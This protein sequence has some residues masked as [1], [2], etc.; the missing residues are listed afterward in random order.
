MFTEIF[1][2]HGDIDVIVFN[3]VYMGG[4]F[5]DDGASFI[6]ILEYY[7]FVYHTGVVG[8]NNPIF[9]HLDNGGVFISSRWPILKWQETVYDSF[10]FGSADMLSAKGAMYASVE[11]SAY[12]VT[13]TYHI[14]GTHLQ[15]GNNRRV[16]AKVREKQ[17]AQMHRLM[18]EQKI[19]KSEPVIFAGDLNI[20]YQ[21][22]YGELE[23]L[24]DI[25]SATMPPIVGSINCTH[26]YQNNDILAPSQRTSEWIDYALYSHAHRLPVTASQ[27]AIKYVAAEPFTVCMDK[28]RLFGGYRY[29]YQCDETKVIT[30]LSD[31]Y[32]VLGKF[33]FNDSE[34]IFYKSSTVPSQ[35]SHY[36][37]LQVRARLFDHFIKVNV[38]I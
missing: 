28:I 6:Q 30:D 31:H 27:E 23:I 34:G 35:D 26:D 24:L 8:E 18:L 14:L 33:S 25:L 4:C 11:K 19:P 22:R 38:T 36:F 13:A 2:R 12:G 20:G 21:S 32:A 16:F 1:A 37:D 10:V 9:P 29:P 15:N 5:P 7:G 17:A 3:E